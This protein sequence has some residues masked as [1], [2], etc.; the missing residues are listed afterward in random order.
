MTHLITEIGAKFFALKHS[1]LNKWSTDVHKI[2]F[3][4]YWT[5]FVGFKKFEKKSD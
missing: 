4:R 5:T 2:Y 3:D 1:E